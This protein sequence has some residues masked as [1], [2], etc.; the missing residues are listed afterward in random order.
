MT[1]S[2]LHRAIGRLPARQRAPSAAAC[3]S[4]FAARFRFC[5]VSNGC[6]ERISQPAAST[7]ISG[8]ERMVCQI[9][10]QNGNELSIQRLQGL[11]ASAGVSKP[12]LWR[13]VLHSPLIFRRAP[14]I[15]SVIQASSHALQ[16]V[17]ERT[18]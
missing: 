16:S 10:P 7:L 4:R 11:C 17:T 14:G 9:L 8:A 13:I 3:W 6:V 2:D 5:R 1:L 12:N 15:Y 18:A